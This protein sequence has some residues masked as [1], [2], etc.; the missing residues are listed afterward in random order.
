MDP[1]MD[2]TTHIPAGLPRSTEGPESALVDLQGLMESTTIKVAW[3]KV[4][5]DECERWNDM[6]IRRKLSS[7]FNLFPPP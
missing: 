1:A 4:A 6:S 2:P 3:L 5:T 7:S